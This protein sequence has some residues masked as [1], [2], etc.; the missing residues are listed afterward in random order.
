MPMKPVSRMMSRMSVNGTRGKEFH[1]LAPSAHLMFLLAGRR[2][3][4]RV[5]VAA[6]SASEVRRVML[7]DALSRRS[8]GRPGDHRF[9][10]DGPREGLG[11]GGRRIA[12]VAR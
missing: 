6:S 1:R 11:R 7:Y 9:G 2:L 8:A 10:G 5:S 4:A 3:A 12:R